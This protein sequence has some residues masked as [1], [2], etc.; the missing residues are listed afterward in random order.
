MKRFWG[1]FLILGLGCVILFG[2]KKQEEVETKK[3]EKKPVIIEETETVDPHEGMAISPI[4]GDW[5][6][7]SIVE[8]RPIAMMFENTKACLPHYGITKGDVI[9]ECPVEGGITRYMVI[10]QDYM[11]M[12]RIGNVRSCRY[13]YPYFAKEFDAI[14]VHAGYNTY[15]ETV[16][17]NGFIEHLDGCSGTDGEY[18]FRTTDAKAPHNLYTSS[19]LLSNAINN[20]GFET[21]ISSDF[22][23]YLYAREED[24]SV[25]GTN[26]LRV[27]L[28]YTNGHPYFLYNSNSKL[29]ERYEFEEKEMDAAFD[30]QISVKNIIIQNCDVSY[31]DAEA[32]TL[33]VFYASS[34]SGYYVCN[35]TYQE[36]SW[37]RES[38]YDITHYYDA[39]G[40][41]LK[42]SPGKTWVAIM[43]NYQANQVTFSDSIE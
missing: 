39:L 11:S 17:N 8:N 43:P 31:L 23:H 37:K 16:L 28:P 27:S 3:P 12:E 19:E 1:K 20:H 29:Y 24:E 36:I 33:K 15:A 35:G 9:Y 2:C 42:L 13:Y 6:D 25:E 22:S 32:G 41:E 7:E 30:Q 4:T 21:K 40:N 18:F 34:G 5:V 26:A 38:D 14:Y 10:M